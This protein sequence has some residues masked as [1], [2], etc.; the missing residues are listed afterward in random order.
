MKRTTN[1]YQLVNQLTGSL[2]P[3]LLTTTVLPL[4]VLAGFGFFSLVERG[5]WM[6]FFIITVA[7]CSMVF[8]WYWWTRKKRVVDT[9]VEDEL[10]TVNVDS[11]PIWTEH[12]NHVWHELNQQIK[13]LLE[14]NPNWEALRDHSLT[15][16]TYAASQYHRGVTSQQLAFTA[17]EFLFMVE[18][19][20]RRYRIFLQEHI[21][22]AEKIRLTTLKQGYAMKDKVSYA[23]AAYDVYR[24]FRL[25]TPF[26]W[27]AEARGLV[28]GKLFDEVSGEV[29]YTLKQTLLQ[30]VASVAIDLYSGQFKFIDASLAQSKTTQHDNNHL[31]EEIEPLRVAVIGQ[32]SAGKSSVVNALLGDIAAEVSALPTTDKATVYTCEVEGCDLIHLVDLPGIDGQADTTQQLMRQVTNSDVVLWILKANQSA[33]NLD[34]EL[35]H[36]ID[37]FYH[38]ATNQNRKEPKILAL[39]SQVDRLQ[40]VNEWLP[41][42]DLENPQTPKATVIRDAVAYNRNLLDPDAILAVSVSSDKAPYQVDGVRALL[43]NAYE[44]G[45]NTQLNRRRIEGDSLDY[46]EQAKRLYRLGKLVF[47]QVINT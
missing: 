10:N 1:K 24:L 40:P 28:I 20:S 44:D 47:Q 36:A 29:Q 6:L 2:V 42:Y 46:S 34:V 22:F 18:E 27:L 9:L 38:K 39:V 32:V 13:D 5:Q 21:P 26:G 35:K 37:S 16:V 19:V 8:V 7:S 3:L 25:A 11:N 41:P 15:L 30:E 33:R 23:K 17:P 31:A 45:V 43:Q 12:D 14:Q 4:L